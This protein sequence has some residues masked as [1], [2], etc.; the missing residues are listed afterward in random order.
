MY[1]STFFNGVISLS[2]R[3]ASIFSKYVVIFFLVKKSSIETYGEYSVVVSL[4]TFG[5]YFLGLDYYTYNNRKLVQVEKKSAFLEDVFSFYLTVFILSIPIITIVH[6]L[7]YLKWEY[8][9]YFLALLFFDY[10]SQEFFRTL[11]SL[12]KIIEA[13]IVTFIK[14]ATFS[15]MTIAY[16]MFSK[17]LVSDLYI[18]YLIWAA[19]SLLAAS[20]GFKKITQTVGYIKIKPFNFSFKKIKEGISVSIP[21][22]IGT[23]L[24]QSMFTIDKIFLVK[25]TNNS[26]IG[27]Y[28]FFL[29]LCLMIMTTIEVAIVNQFLP[30]LLEYNIKMDFSNLNKT[31]KLF[32]RL[33]FAVSLGS[34]IGF[35]L[36]KDIILNIFD[37][38]ELYANNDIFYMLL[39]S[40]ILLC[41]SLIP[42]YKLYIKGKD[43]DIFI[44]TII[45]FAGFVIFNLLFASSLK[46]KGVCGSLVLSFGLLLISKMYF[47]SKT[48]LS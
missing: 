20:Y 16:L 46:E 14:N 42:H 17:N 19:S 32:K 10:F 37:K 25:F 45:S 22:F 12:K 5:I 30:L 28:S 27:I 26:I 6:S 41:L 31:Y 36:F 2:I 34:L 8:F 24:Y 1:N 43:K 35:L 9:F 44:S 7:G 15:V 39:T 11:I 3:F 48:R 13:N 23:L 33:V 47:S 40:V 21:F 29:Y 18:I 38:A 4:S